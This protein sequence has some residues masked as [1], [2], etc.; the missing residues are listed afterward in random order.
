[1]F[2][3]GRVVISMESH[4]NEKVNINMTCWIHF[5]ISSQ[6]P[7]TRQG[8]YPIKCIPCRT[9]IIATHARDRSVSLSSIAQL[10]QYTMPFAPPCHPS[11]ASILAVPAVP[12]CVTSR[13]KLLRF[14]GIPY[15][16][17]LIDPGYHP[18]SYSSCPPCGCCPC[19]WYPTPSGCWP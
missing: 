8:P 2:N 10:Y 7:S 13:V 5:I 6:H 15:V 17:Q 12:P 19:C 16:R 4:V 14:A 9:L 18:P 1:L 3:L 11:S